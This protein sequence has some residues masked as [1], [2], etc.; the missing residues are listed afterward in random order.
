MFQ[1]IELP[2]IFTIFF[3]YREKRDKFILLFGIETFCPFDHIFDKARGFALDEPSRE[4]V[5]E[6]RI[7]LFF[8]C[9]PVLHE[10]SVADVF[11]Y[12]HRFLYLVMVYRKEE[13]LHSS[14]FMSVYAFSSSI[15]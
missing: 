11:V 9:K 3:R 8:E 2:D 4:T 13:L 14:L 6:T 10:G 1:D 15:K 7:V 12:V 5:A